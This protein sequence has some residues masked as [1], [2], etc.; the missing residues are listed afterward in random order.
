MHPVGPHGE[1]YVWAIVHD[2]QRVVTIRRLAE[3]ARVVQQIA[4][5]RVPVPHW[6]E[7]LPQRDSGQ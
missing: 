4:R 7:I 3:H 6:Y 5:L 2:E 1:G